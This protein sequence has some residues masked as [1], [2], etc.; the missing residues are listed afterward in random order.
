MCAAC[1]ASGAG[2]PRALSAA[3]SA[4]EVAASSGLFWGASHALDDVI[5]TTGRDVS[6]VLR[7]LG[8]RA[9]LARMFRRLAHVVEA[10]ILIKLAPDALPALA[11]GGRWAVGAAVAAASGAA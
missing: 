1:V 9:G 4:L 10:S 2:A 11:E 5:T 7:G 6:H 3:A 8:P